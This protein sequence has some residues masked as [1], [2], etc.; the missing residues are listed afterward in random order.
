MGRIIEELLM[1][2]QR[3]TGLWGIVDVLTKDISTH[4]DREPMAL[5]NLIT[6]MC[7]WVLERIPSLC[8]YPCW[9]YILFALWKPWWKCVRM[10]RYWSSSSRGRLGYLSSH[11]VLQPKHTFF[12]LG[13]GCAYHSSKNIQRRVLSELSEWKI[14]HCKG[15]STWKELHCERGC[16]TK[17]ILGKNWVLYRG[18]LAVFAFSQVWDVTQHEQ[19]VKFIKSWPLAPKEYA[20]RQ[21]CDRKRPETVSLQCHN[22][23]DGSRQ[24]QTAPNNCSHLSALLWL[25][26]FSLL[27]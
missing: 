21:G 2:F 22:T 16:S 20:S 13:L 19:W 26:A 10:C 14:T 18:K 12:C 6:C 1:G 23:T 8:V 25:S 3:V 9:S 15:P 5:Q 11:G 27:L 7:V 24:L 17:K 4:K